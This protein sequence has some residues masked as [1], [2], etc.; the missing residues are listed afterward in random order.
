[1]N[2]RVDALITEARSLTPEERDEL[3][4]QL[5]LARED[6]EPAD[7]TPEEI[8]A[9]W[10]AEVERRITARERG[11]VVLHDADDVLAG[12][13]ARVAAWLAKA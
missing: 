10:T 5:V 7:G 12:A 4:L 9:A 3:M 2:K 6:D 8:E 13:R 11:E 1:M